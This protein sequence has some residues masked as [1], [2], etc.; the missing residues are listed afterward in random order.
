M[1]TYRAVFFDAGETLVHPHPSFPDLFAGALAEEGLQVDPALVRRRLHL[2]SD[3]F[4][5]AAD[6]G[7]LWSV[8]PETSRSFWASVYRDFVGELGLP[9]GDGLAERLYRTFTDLANYRLFDDV[10]GTLERLHAGGMLLG[11]V[12]N[13]EDWL[14]GLLDLLGVTAF[15]DVR[16]ISG[17]EGVEKP[18]HR[19]FLLALER[20]GVPA[21]HAVY[22]GDSPTF[23]VEPAAAVG[24]LAVLIDR[25]GAH[26]DHQGP[27]ISSLREL[28]AILGVDP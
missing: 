26:P 14:E 19:M 4:V 10:I 2:I 8:S 20:S 11:V 27:R 15:V 17:V 24:M 6:E 9:F 13:F 21:E 22:V 5:K 23:D 25:H 18:N 12:S 7:E 16:V 1:P 28:P 3:R